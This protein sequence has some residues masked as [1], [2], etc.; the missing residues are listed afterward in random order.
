VTPRAI[1]STV[2]QSSQSALSHSDRSPTQARSIRQQRSRRGGL[3]AAHST[4]SRVGRWRLCT[5][6]PPGS[7]YHRCLN[8]SGAN[9]TR[10]HDDRRSSS[11]ATGPAARAASATANAP[12][13]CAIAPERPRRRQNLDRLGHP[14]LQPRHPR[15]PEHLTRSPNRRRNTPAADTNTQKR[16]RPPRGRFISRHRQ[17]RVLP[18]QIATE[19]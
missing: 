17:T 12:T 6:A 8:G 7:G 9:N 3:S 11:R 13:A 14:Y 19:S 4:A 2:S 16:P 15:R 1:A 18:R 10:H 5:A